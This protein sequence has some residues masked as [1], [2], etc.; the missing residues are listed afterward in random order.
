MGVRSGVDGRQA[1][2]RSRWAAIGAAVAV[3]LGGGGIFV[4]N[5]ASSMPS[6]VVTIDPARILDTRNP[7]NVGLAGPFVSAVSQRL[8][9]TG[10]VA[11]ST[12][13]R[14]VVPSGATGV[15]L[16]VT[17]VRPTAAGFVSIRP[18]DATGAPSTSSLNFE[19]GAVVPNAVQVGLPTT[20]ANAGQID[21]TYDAYGV[22]GPSTEML[23]DVVGYMVEGGGGATGPTGP[24][25]DTGPAGSAGP[26][27]P[28][29][30]TG[31]TG[32][33]GPD[34]VDGAPGA[35]A[36]RPRNVIWVSPQGGDFTSIQAALDSITF[37]SFNN[38]WL[39]KVG[40]GTYP[41]RITL[42]SHVTIEGSGQG[43]TTIVSSGGTTSDGS[44]AAVRI[45]NVFF[46]QLR[47]LTINVEEFNGGIGYGIY[48]N[49]T[50]SSTEIR[51]VTVWVDGAGAA[52]GVKNVN[53]SPSLLNVDIFVIGTTSGI[54]VDN[55]GSSAPELVHIDVTAWSD[56]GFSAGVANFD[57]AAPTIR[58]SVIWARF[59]LTNRSIRNFT[60]T[61]AKVSN[62]MLRGV[63]EGG[64]FACIGA[65][66]F[67]FAALSST[68][69]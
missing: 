31:A 5:A 58:D 41:E 30:D 45:G 11:T 23:I 13:T 36:A 27:G 69:S 68:C 42:K 25:G 1:L 61:S 40:P 21:I 2:W 17:V 20:G 12:G 15:L 46:A 37:S 53:A 55:E 43:K 50:S 39:I 54:G 62:T 65:H 38:P 16:N 24:K 28:K 34:G 9:V 67:S 60:G 7:L 32:P 64:G 29:G 10:S 35:D 59:G 19:A 6:S 49:Q 66:G 18:G 51:D 3:T 44:S 8:Q 48:A 52:A 63:V 4:A 22:A 56:D 57:T 26:P 33:Q 47:D 14:T